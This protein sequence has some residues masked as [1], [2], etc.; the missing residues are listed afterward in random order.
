MT[1]ALSVYLDLLRAAA[2]LVVFLGHFAIQRH[3]GGYLWQ[4]TAHG[5]VAVIVFFVLSGFVIAWTAE[6]KE[7]EIR[8]FALA[9][10]AR[11]LSV[12]VPA[13]ALTLAADYAGSKVLAYPYPDTWQL[14]GEDFAARYVASLLFLNQSWGW[15]FVPGSNIPYWSLPYE[16]WYYALF[17]AAVFLR[18]KTRVAALVAASLVAGPR[19]LLLA[20]VWL[21]GVA[22]WR[23]YTRLPS[24]SAVLI[25]VVTALLFVLVEE[26]AGPL[27]TGMFGKDL[28][29]IALGYEYV[30]G[31]L[32]ALHLAAVA[33]LG[34]VPG[35][36]RVAAP[37]RFAARNSFSLY[38]YHYPLLGVAAAAMPGNYPFIFVA[39]LAGVLLLARVTE[40]K[41]HVVRSWLEALIPRGAPAPSPAR[42]R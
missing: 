9:R 38:L 14:F 27:F 10:L 4:F 6:T 2:A 8:S 26:T 30:L 42:G 11:L 15:E 20:P 37:I 3:G 17:G 22:A 13:L 32:A 1:P 33:R 18:G 31:A 5:H 29:N 28:A 21:M 24:A 41:K 25:A 39:S 36:L 12:T 19:V 23:L 35:L 7:R 16:F 34:G 40:A